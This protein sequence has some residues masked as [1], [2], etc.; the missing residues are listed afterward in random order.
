MTSEAWSVVADLGAAEVVAPLVV[1]ADPVAAVVRAVGDGGADDRTGDDP[2]A[3]RRP[4]AVEVMGLRLADHQGGAERESGD[5]R[6]DLRLHEGVLDKGCRCG[7][8]GR[9]E[10]WSMRPGSRFK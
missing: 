9:D 8:V 7:R 2:G 1:L 5:G 4:A 6:D 3:E 10:R